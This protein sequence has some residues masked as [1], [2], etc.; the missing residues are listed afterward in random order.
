[1]SK[2]LHSALR[3][4]AVQIYRAGLEAVAPDSAIKAQCRL[5]GA[6]LTVGSSRYDLDKYQRIIVLGAGKAGASMAKAIEQLLGDRISAGLV[7]VKYGHVEKLETIEL[8]EAGHPLPDANGLAAARAIYELAQSADE[9]TLAVGLISGGGS[10]LLPLPVDQVSLE[11]KQEATRMLLASG[12]RIHEINAIR[13][14]LSLIKGGGLAKAVFP[15]T[16][17]T[18]LLS[19][20]VGD[21]LDSIASGPC[22]P[23]STS[24]ADCLAIVEKYQ[25]GSC[26]PETVFSY[27][28]SGAAGRAEETPK[29][30]QPFFQ[31]T[32]NLIVASNFNALNQARLKAEELGYHSL[33]LSSMIQGETRVVA[34]NHVAIAREIELH[35]LPVPR[36]ACLL[37]GGETT[38]TIKGT[39]KGGRNQ[40]FVLA[41]ARELA[42]FEDIVVFSA[43]TDGTD[44]PTDAAGA[45]A[46]N[47]TLARAAELDLDAGAF[48][49][50]NDAYHFFDRLNDLYK[51]GPTHTNVMDLRILIVK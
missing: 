9:Q 36:P 25:L 22:V 16:L 32:Q 51:T 26:L 40:E 23:D 33:L 10:A 47:Q 41:A 44:G 19:D 12:A 29:A 3:D 28:Q 34:Q 21:D 7:C 1:M 27:L 8:M 38:V 30:D 37:S 20:V 43:G 15:A 24:Y 50:N 46:D 17:I 48:L 2:T 5:E 11:D 39:G 18:L 45:I 35:D 6:V 31:Q 14:H 4:A 42:H 49:N 13:K